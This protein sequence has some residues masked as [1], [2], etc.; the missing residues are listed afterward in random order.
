MH[1]N[2]GDARSASSAGMAG[3]A[4]AVAVPVTVRRT[5]TTPTIA[6]LT[7]HARRLRGRAQGVF[8][9]GL[10]IEA[11]VMN[12]NDAMLPGAPMTNAMATGA[13]PVRID[14]SGCDGLLDPNAYA[15]SAERDHGEG[16]DQFDEHPPITQQ[17]PLRGERDQHPAR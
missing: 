7:F 13:A 17:T 12:R 16:D 8:G 3:K 5:M 6:D 11:Q 9:H 10:A 15:E 2:I 4:G 1:G 14:C